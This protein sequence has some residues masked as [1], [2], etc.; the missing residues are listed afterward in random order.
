LLDFA[1]WFS[2]IILVKNPFFRFLYTIL[3]H[4]WNLRRFDGQGSAREHTGRTFLG[5][6]GREFVA[7]A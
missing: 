5:L 7:M 2:L 1:E 4:L 3:S 6:V